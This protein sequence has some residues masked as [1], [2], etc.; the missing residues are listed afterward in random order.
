MY[1]NVLQCA[2][3]WML[4]HSINATMRDDEVSRVR[5]GLRAKRSANSSDDSGEVDV[6]YDSDDL[7]S[8]KSQRKNNERNG[9]Q[10]ENL[11]SDSDYQSD[12]EPYNPD[13]LHSERL[14]NVPTTKQPLETGVVHTKWGPIAA[15]RLI[16][17]TFLTR[18]THQRQIVASLTTWS[19]HYYRDSGG[20]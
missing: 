1:L 15:G 17:G 10:M 14:T 5:F 9:K 11:A 4:S 7:P 16:A 6:H 20:T 2:L 12:S 19:A 8:K 3:H 13:G 18:Y